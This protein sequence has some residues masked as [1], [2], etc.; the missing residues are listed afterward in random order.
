MSGV[1]AGAPT[2]IAGK[3]LE[4]VA[5]SATSKDVSYN[6]RIS[7]ARNP[8]PMI[9][10]PKM[11]QPVPRRGPLFCLTALAFGLYATI[12]MVTVSPR[13]LGS[14]AGYMDPWDSAAPAF[15]W[16]VAY[17]CGLAA[18]STDILK[19]AMPGRR[20]LLEVSV[21]AR[22]CAIASGILALAWREEGISDSAYALVLFYVPLLVVFGA[23]L[24][25]QGSVNVYASMCPGGGSAGSPAETAQPTKERIF[26]T[27]PG[28]AVI[29]V[30]FFFCV[31]GGLGRVG[32]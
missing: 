25:T 31:H 22:N 16:A 27:P 1:P 7:A 4:G 5:A 19:W 10:L 3:S 9:R 28:T 15:I 21:W 6:R 32:N 20:R 26:P 14:L 17:G 23:A 11:N 30:G 13:S 8:D 29:V 18:I 24:L 2:G 12:T